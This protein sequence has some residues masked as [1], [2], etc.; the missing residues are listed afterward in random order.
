[1]YLQMKKLNQ[2][3]RFWVALN[4]L[5]KVLGRMENHYLI[6]KSPKSQGL[7]VFTKLTNY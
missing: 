3:A 6:Y 4:G 5:R 1:M 7:Q 2:I